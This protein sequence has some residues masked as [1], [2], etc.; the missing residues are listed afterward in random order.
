MEP[1]FGI[2][3]QATDATWANCAIDGKPLLYNNAETAQK[4][5]RWLRD[6]K[7]TAHEWGAK[8]DV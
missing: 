1:V 7:G 2:Q 6:P 4:H 8:T 5:L 3:R